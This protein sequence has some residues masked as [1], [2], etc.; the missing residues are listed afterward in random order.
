MSA[1]CPRTAVRTACLPVD[2]RGTLLGVKRLVLLGFA[3]LAVGCTRSAGTNRDR[4]VGTRVVG[5]AAGIELADGNERTISIRDGAETAGP[6]TE[7]DAGYVVIDVIDVDLDADEPDEQII[8]AKVH[9]DVEDR[10]RLIV[11]DFDPLLS[12]YRASWEGA[13]LATNVRTFVVRPLDMVGD[14]VPEIVAVGA[15]A[16]GRQTLDVF[17]RLRT[18]GVRFRSV[19]SAHSDGSI[20]INE[21]SRSEAYVGRQASGESFSIEVY[22]LN[23]ATEEPF[24]LVRTSY[25]WQAQD[26]RYAPD[27]VVAVAGNEVQQQRLRLPAGA[28]RDELERHLDGPWLRDGGMIV[29]F[30]RRARVSAFSTST[31]QVRYTWLTTGSAYSA[32]GTVAR[33]ALQNEQLPSVRRSMSVVLIGLH[34]IRV[35]VSDDEERSGRYRRMAANERDVAVYTDAAAVQTV[36]LVGVFSGEAD[37]ELVFDEPRFQW[38]SPRRNW[39][40]AFNVLVFDAPILELRVYDDQ[41][42]RTAAFAI[43]Y[44]EYQQSAAQTLR[45]LTLRPVE[46]LVSGP[47]PIGGT[48]IVF[49]QIVEG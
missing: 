38:R 46:L 1:I 34:E 12:R 6:A 20:T 8:T 33:I 35:V 16:E 27:P 39:S 31:S 24:D 26:E 22:R 32:S 43:E 44:G 30:D 5:A 10:I 4:R 41:T 19:F 29:F 23:D 15:D 3:L 25:R 49:E 36:A 37:D 7:L 47:E 48:P 17:R 2:R 9:G 28:D 18:G 13:T 21:L 42:I 40:G 11:A 45:R 14:H